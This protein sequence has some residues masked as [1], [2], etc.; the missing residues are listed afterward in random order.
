MLP[1]YI[2]Y[3]STYGG[4]LGE[5]EFVIGVAKAGL[6]LEELTF[7]RDIPFEMQFRFNYAACELTDFIAS[8]SA[9]TEARGAIKSENIDGYAV[10]Y[11]TGEDIVETQKM[12]AI[13]IAQ[14]WLTWPINLLYCGR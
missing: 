10:T 3:T 2:F 4:K 9:G 8:D 6:L 1:D 7:S 13:S 11:A 5:P 14:Q 12:K